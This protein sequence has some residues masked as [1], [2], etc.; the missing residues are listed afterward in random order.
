LLT[1][2]FRG[3]PFNRKDGS[4]PSVT[5]KAWSFVCA[6]FA[7]FEP[8]KTSFASKR[9]AERKRIIV[10]LDYLYNIIIINSAPVRPASLPGGNQP[11]IVRYWFD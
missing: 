8:L 2:I 5:H 7:D 9:Y 6:R 1:Q 10:V 11:V 4:P 3:S